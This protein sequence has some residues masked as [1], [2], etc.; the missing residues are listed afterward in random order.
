MKQHL[1]KLV[2]LALLLT[3][4]GVLAIHTIALLLTVPG[5]LAIHTIVL[6]PG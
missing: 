5:G 1:G 2:A 3:V 6:P 4:L